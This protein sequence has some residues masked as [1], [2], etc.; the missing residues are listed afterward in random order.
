MKLPLK[1]WKPLTRELESFTRRARSMVTHFSSPRT[2]VMRRKCLE[3]MGNHT[4]RTPLIMV[5]VFIPGLILTI[6]PLVPFI[7][8]SKEQSFVE[9]KVGVLADVAPTILDLMGLPIPEEMDGKS[10]L[11]KN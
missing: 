3:T 1:E 6:S 2:M 4:Q 9:G 11:K 7:M 8:T 5:K 10:L